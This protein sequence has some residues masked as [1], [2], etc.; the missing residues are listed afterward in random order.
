VESGALSAVAATSSIG[1]REGKLTASRERELT[2]QTEQWDVDVL[3]PVRNGAKYVEA[4][5][6]SVRSQTLQP[7]RVVVVDDGSTD[8]TPVLLRR[9]A[10]RWAKLRVLR[11]EPAGVSH[12]RNLGLAACEARFVAFLD[13]DDV[14]APEKLERQMALLASRRSVGWVH[15][16]YFLIDQSGRTI[17]DATIFPPTKRGNIFLD[18]LDQYPLS[19]SASA[20]V[21]RRD[22]VVAA[23]GFDEAL[24]HGEDWDLWLRLA[25][26]AQ[27]DFVPEPLVGIRVHEGSS[28]RRGFSGRRQ[29]FFFQRLHVANKW[30]GEDTAR[31]AIIG[32]FR[33]EAVSVRVHTMLAGERDC[34]LYA[35]LRASDLVLA[36]LLFRWRASYWLRI[37]RELG[38]IAIMK[39]VR[40]VAARMRGASRFPDRRL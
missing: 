31:G 14:W 19:G 30:I 21:A 28:Q 10:E 18:L 9:Y 1:A 15:C 2:D 12:A 4:C 8:E 32:R 34:D 5:L 25:R 20:V 27:V 36:G 6:D 37:G 23:G 17:P 33:A 38:Y 24:F 29:T 22:L 13:S 7:S 26:L 40:A 35:R 11:S 3:I 16:S 39:A